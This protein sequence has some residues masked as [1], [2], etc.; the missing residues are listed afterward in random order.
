MPASLPALQSASVNFNIRN[1]DGLGKS[2]WQYW[3]MRFSK[4]RMIGGPIVAV[5]IIG[6][7]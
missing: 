2:R 1:N 6:Y 4:K 7:R 3:F 5:L